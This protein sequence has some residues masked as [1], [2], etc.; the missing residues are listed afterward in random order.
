MNKPNQVCLRS[1]HDAACLFPSNVAFQSANA[2][3]S[4]ETHQDNK[5]DPLGNYCCVLYMCQD[6]GMGTKH[7]HV[8]SPIM[9]KYATLYG[10]PTHLQGSI[11]CE[12]D[13]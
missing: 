10:V 11:V 3:Y 4:V 13:N 1:Q 6:V 7:C 5:R 9:Q 2:I 12:H 8:F